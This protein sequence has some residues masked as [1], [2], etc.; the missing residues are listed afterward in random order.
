M[1]TSNASY[2]R[3]LQILFGALIMGL[4]AFSAIVF[5]LVE[6]QE[7]GGSDLGMQ[8]LI[9]VVGVTVASIAAGMLISKRVLDDIKPDA[10]V[11][12]KLDRY[13][14]AQ[15]VRYVTAEGP[16]LLAQI[17]FLLTGE[18]QYFAL[19]ALLLGYLLW[20]RPT[21]DKIIQDLNLNQEE[22]KAL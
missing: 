12:E 7:M 8:F 15:L 9:I 11:G 17:G 4:V 14:S 2:L 10:K 3:V 20:M 5:F 6:G 13:R 1:S 21:R 19:G 18:K 16:G 22:Q